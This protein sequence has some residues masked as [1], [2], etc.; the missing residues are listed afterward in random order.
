MLCEEC[1][2]CACEFCRRK[3]KAKDCYSDSDAPP[4]TSSGENENT[5]DGLRKLPRLQE[6]DDDDDGDGG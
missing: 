2:K 4:T 5:D 3:A 6:S 1:T